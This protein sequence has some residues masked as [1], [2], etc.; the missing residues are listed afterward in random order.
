MRNTSSSFLAL[1]G[2]AVLYARNPLFPD[3][4]RAGSPLSFKPQAKCYLRA[5]AFSSPFPLL[6]SLSHHAITP[7]YTPTPTQLAEAGMIGFVPLPFSCPIRRKAQKEKSAV[8]LTAV[9]LYLTCIY[10]WSACGHS[11]VSWDR[12]TDK[13]VCDQGFAE[14]TPLGARGR[15]GIGQDWS[16]L[17]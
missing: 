11:M 6:G 17:L 15:G 12:P 10:A 7:P 14:R 2:K 3:L 1:K 9:T 8:F 5:E 13:G 16:V 4:G